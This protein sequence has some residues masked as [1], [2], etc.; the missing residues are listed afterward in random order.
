M[1]PMAPLL[2]R[3]RTD[4]DLE[5]VASLLLATHHSDAWVAVDADADGEVV[6]HVAL[7]AVDPEEQPAEQWVAAT[8]RSPVQLGAVRR[9]VVHERVQG[10]GTGRAL[11][12]AS[13]HA[14]HALGLRPVLDM[15]DN[16]EAA[17]RMYQRA[18]FERIGSYELDL[19][20]YFPPG[21]HDVEIGGVR[22]RVLH[23]LT[24]VG[25]EAPPSR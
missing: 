5:A 20:E 9:L 1:G 19:T 22:T 12:A 17:G 24:W 15:A 14:A 18:G 3:R 11:L 7:T 2:I 4:Q 13:V 21:Q 10:T 23:V 8:G 25:P 16:L 6:G